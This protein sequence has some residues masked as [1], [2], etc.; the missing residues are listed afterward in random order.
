MSIKQDIEMLSEIEVEVL[1]TVTKLINSKYSPEAVAAVLAK[2]TY[3]VY[4]SILSPSDYQQMAQCLY[5]YRLDVRSF[6]EFKTEL[7]RQIN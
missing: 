7:D 3:A 1:N 6:R 4:K 2:T 5:D